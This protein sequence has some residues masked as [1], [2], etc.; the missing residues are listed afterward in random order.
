MLIL[1]ILDS[2]DQSQKQENQGSSQLTLR[3]HLE[4]IYARNVY[5]FSQSDLMRIH[6]EHYWHFLV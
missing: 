1:N 6:C 3:Y 2:E 4:A 5:K